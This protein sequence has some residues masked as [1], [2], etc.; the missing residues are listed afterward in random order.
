[1]FK[2]LCNSVSTDEFCHNW[3][4]EEADNMGFEFYLRAG[5]SPV[6][7]LAFLNDVLNDVELGQNEDNFFVSEPLTPE[8]RE[9]CSKFKKTDLADILDGIKVDSDPP[10]GKAPHPHTCWRLYKTLVVEMKDHK[11][12]YLAF[13]RKSARTD[14]FHPSVLKTLQA[15]IR[16]SNQFEELLNRPK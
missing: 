5:Y 7:Y 14:W 8:I 15:M 11:E 12:E 6:F 9:I 2:D 3:A 13:I 4:E 10:R 16:A 1:M